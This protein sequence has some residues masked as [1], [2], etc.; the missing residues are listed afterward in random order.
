M[1]WRTTSSLSART[2]KPALTRRF[3]RRKRRFDSYRKT[4]RSLSWRFSFET[5]ILE[6]KLRY[7]ERIWLKLNRRGTNSERPAKGWRRKGHAKWT[8]WTRDT[9]VSCRSS[10][11]NWKRRNVFTS[12][13]FKKSTL[14]QRSNYNCSSSSMNLRN[15]VL[16]SVSTTKK[17]V[18]PAELM[19]LYGNTSKSFAKSL[20]ITRTRWRWF[21]AIL[22]TQL[23]R[24]SR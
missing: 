6:R 2:C 3:H 5:P 23:R 1:T 18:T 10:N 15:N 17:N 14:N 13:S 16:N 21:R 4:A 22:T 24:T 19:N 12:S 20:I 7:W 11:R 8:T 9:T